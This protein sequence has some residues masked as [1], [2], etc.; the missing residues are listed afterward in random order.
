MTTRYDNSYLT[1]GCWSPTRP[2][3][4]YTTKAD[5]TVDVWD[6]YYKQND[7]TFSTKI[8][9]SAIR[10]I[11]CEKTRGA[12]CAIGSK[13]GTTTIIQMSSGLVTPHHDEKQQL[14][15]MFEREK[16]REKNLDSRALQRKNE[17]KKHQ[18]EMAQER[19][20]FD[21]K[22]DDPAPIKTKLAE[23][24]ARFYKELAIDKNAPRGSIKTGSES[25]AKIA[26]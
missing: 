16:D 15:A 21:P 4:Y 9:D 7:P 17:E 3:V 12:L 24:E 2:G 20:V 13:D 18:R 8:S 1:S 22:A 10:T 6:I 23:I 25:A 14:L 11:K 26:E 19:I 5:G